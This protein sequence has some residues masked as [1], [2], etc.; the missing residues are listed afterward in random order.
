MLA[1]LALPNPPVNAMREGK[2]LLDG[3]RR[4]QGQLADI[5]ESTLRAISHAMSIR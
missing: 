4:F 2:D 3:L 1:A 5:D